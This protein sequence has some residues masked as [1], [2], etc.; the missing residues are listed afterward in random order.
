[1]SQTTPHVTAAM[2]HVTASQPG[3][4]ASTL[5]AGLIA[6]LAGVILPAFS[7]WFISAAALAGLGGAVAG[8]N[9]LLPS[10]AIRFLAIARTGGRYGQQIAGHIVALHGVADIR[11]A[12]FAALTRGPVTQSLKLSRGEG[13][14]RLIQDVGALELWFIARPQTIVT[15]VA[16]FTSIALAGLS[17][18]RSAAAIALGASLVI[19]TSRQALT[20]RQTRL[21]AR[22][23]AETE[24]MKGHYLSILDGAAELLNARGFATARR[25]ILAPSDTLDRIGTRQTALRGLQEALA[26]LVAPSAAILAY[27]LST[28]TLPYR[29][30]AALA[31]LG[32]IEAAHQLARLIDDGRQADQSARRL[33]EC[34]TTP[35]DE[36]GD[37][38]RV[39]DTLTIAWQRP[40]LALRAGGISILR[41]PSGCGKTTLLERLQG[42]RDAPRGAIFL[43]GTDLS[44]IALDERRRMFAY[45]PQHPSLLTGTVRDNLH[46]AAPDASEP[47]LLAALRAS[48]L[49]AYVAAL[50]S[51][52]DTWIGETGERLS[53][54]QQKRLAIARA[55]LKP[56]PFL[57]LDEPT[58][59]LDSVTA[60]RLI[61]NIT[62]WVRERRQT[63]L[64]VSHAADETFQVHDT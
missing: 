59:S 4:V 36:S 49:D 35:V 22:Q 21:A 38:F 24:S 3:L 34:F 45:A 27:G 41:G 50:P 19:V 31:A 10:A 7:G 20:P 51:G 17:G 5:A 40:P 6:A 61:E 37:T 28:E 56:A 55:L 60:A 33:E 46:L 42:L 11:T 54:G 2:R 48:C 39:G 44:R 63:C 25:A 47:E 16:L 26:A 53:G 13:V 15:C 62:A 14:T 8:F 52:L 30:L 23:L 9:Y 57:L 12:L 43:D 18:W 1:M 64:L 29:I 32:G 58:E